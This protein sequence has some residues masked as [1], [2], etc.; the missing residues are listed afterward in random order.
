MV[1]RKCTIS[2]NRACCELYFTK[3]HEDDLKQIFKSETFNQT[4]PDKA[5]PIQIRRIYLGVE[6]VAGVM[7]FLPT[8][9]Y[10]Q[11][12]LYKQFVKISANI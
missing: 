2:I 6:D 12:V 1:T 9:E 4:L 8:E 10:K 3:S 7:H 5:N 11:I